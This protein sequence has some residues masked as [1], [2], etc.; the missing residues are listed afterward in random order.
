MSELWLP[1]DA[2]EALVPVLC[3]IPFAH[4]YCP[5]APEPPQ[6]AFLT[7]EVLEAL[8]GGAAGGGKSDAMLMAALQ[9]VH[10]PNYSAIIMRRTFAELS[11]EGA[12]LS[13]ALS[14]L[15]HTD[16][17]WNGNDMRWRFPSG[18]S[19]QFGYL[20][21]MQDRARYQSAE[22]QFIGIDE[23]TDWDEQDYRFMFSR[24]RGPGF[25]CDGCG[26][27]SSSQ[28]ECEECGG[29]E[30]HAASELSYVPLRM[31]G[32]TNPGGRGHRWVKGRFLDREDG[33]P[34]YERVFIPARLRD[35]PHLN[36]AA[37]L[38]ALSQLDPGQ[39]EMLIEGNWDA[40]E[41]GDW[42]IGDPRWVDAAVE[43]G[44]RIW[45]EG[46]PPPVSEGLRTGTDWGEH[47][48]SYIIWELEHGGVFIPPSEVVAAGQDPA[49]TSHEII[50]GVLRYN[51]PWLSARYDA[52]GV[53]S[54]R[55][56]MGIAR[57]V[58]GLE[59]LR[60]QKVPFNQ[61]KR[62]SI[63]YM[64]TLL[65]RTYLGET[66]RVMAI[67]PDNEELIWQLKEWKFKRIPGT[68]TISDEVVKENDH[69]P[70]AVIAGIAHIA[71]KHQ[72]YIEEKLKEGGNF[73]DDAYDDGKG[74]SYD[75][76]KDPEAARLFAQGKIAEY[77]NR[78]S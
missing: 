41:P 2:A 60:S 52:A 14:W 36:Q 26:E 46:P 62:Q 69:G 39:A 59:N 42:V 13:R 22:F 11:L 20:K 10:V 49:L 27:N 6:H 73:K 71:V 15:G 33:A 61:Y 72:A 43:L 78:P 23:L 67:H 29:T 53:Q 34:A 9:Y 75:W 31:R 12:L 8:Y 68:D 7:L 19:L 37:Y 55:T 47:T 44:Q 16:A 24:L 17:T 76:R 50:R 32:A 4:E 65:R 21:G 3:D 64:R 18:A 38:K 54:M 58:P 70:D 40:R 77:A 5:H 45:E 66:T 63:G 56:L 57:R 28:F 30:L 51:W 1:D 74:E 35:N 48:Q 25:I